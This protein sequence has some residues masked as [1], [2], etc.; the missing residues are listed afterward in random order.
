MSG[1]VSRGLLFRVEE[2]GHDVDR[3]FPLPRFIADVFLA[4]ASELVVFRLATIRRNVPS[5][6]DEALQFELDEGGR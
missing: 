4:G 5:G 1:F 6:C 3:L 2:A